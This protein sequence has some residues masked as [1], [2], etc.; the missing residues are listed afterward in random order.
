MSVCSLGSIDFTGRVEV[1]N[2]LTTT[3]RT[4]WSTS[5]LPVQRRSNCW[6]VSL[7]LPSS[8]LHLI[9][10]RFH[11]SVENNRHEARPHREKRFSDY[12]LLWRPFIAHRTRGSTRR[13]VSTRTAERGGEGTPQ[14]CGRGWECRLA[15]Q[16][17]RPVLHLCPP[18]RPPETDCTSG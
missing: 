13:V 4:A 1:A 3:E 2:V 12:C 7:L 16:R 14:V 9:N 18:P 6:L 15:V 5:S 17:D 10:H 8:R 11:A